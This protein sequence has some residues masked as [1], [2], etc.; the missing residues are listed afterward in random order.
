MR[1]QTQRFALTVFRGTVDEISL[2]SSRVLI[3]RGF[4]RFPGENPLHS[5]LCLGVVT[6]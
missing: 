4:A 2:R 5:Y 1:F 6:A 3:Y